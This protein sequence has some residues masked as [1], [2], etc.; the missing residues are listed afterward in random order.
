MRTPNYNSILVAAE[1]VILWHEK[2]ILKHKLMEVEQLPMPTVLS[3]MTQFYLMAEGRLRY[4]A[5]Y[6]YKPPKID[7]RLNTP[8][9]KFKD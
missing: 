1:R 9:L 5:M 8:P 3:A 7:T 6:G 4:I 2:E